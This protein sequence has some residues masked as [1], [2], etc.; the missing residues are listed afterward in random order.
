MGVRHL[1]PPR[2][3]PQ[4]ILARKIFQFL[5]NNVYW[6]VFL[7]LKIKFGVKYLFFK[8][9]GQSYIRYRRVLL[10]PHLGFIILSL[11]RV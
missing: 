7:F 6:K 3:F 9:I 5:K 8:K 4:I 1:P 11:Y 2:Q 10:Y